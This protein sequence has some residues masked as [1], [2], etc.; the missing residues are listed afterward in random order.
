LLLVQVSAKGEA[1]DVQIKQ[2]SGYPRL[3]EA[4]LNAVRKWRFV[5]ARRGTEPV[6]SSVVVPLVFRLDN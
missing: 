4:A 1:D 2:G 5:P 6:A 3:D